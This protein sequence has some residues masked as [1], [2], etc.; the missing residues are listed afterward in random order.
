MFLTPCLGL[1]VSVEQNSTTRN[2]PGPAPRVQY[3]PVPNKSLARSYSASG[4]L[5]RSSNGLLQGI[6][7]YRKSMIS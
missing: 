4:S 2:G 7:G 1:L 3:H 6:L 5:G